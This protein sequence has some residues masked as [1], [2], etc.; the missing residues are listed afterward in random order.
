MSLVPG[1]RLELSQ[2]RPYQI[3]SL[4]R[5]PISPPRQAAAC[6]CRA[7]PGNVARA[8]QGV[9]AA[10]RRSAV[11]PAGLFAEHAI[12]RVA[13]PRWSATPAMRSIDARTWQ[14]SLVATVALGD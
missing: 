2:A 4:A 7:E 10:R 3:L 1:E 14:L 11:A 6:G 13:R 8:R 5:L 9:N 12:V